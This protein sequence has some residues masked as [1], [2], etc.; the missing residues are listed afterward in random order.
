MGFYSLVSAVAELLEIRSRV[1]AHDIEA[2]W[3]DVLF[4][5]HIID[6]DVEVGVRMLMRSAVEP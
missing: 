3:V 2:V 4:R 5:A 6:N 1:D